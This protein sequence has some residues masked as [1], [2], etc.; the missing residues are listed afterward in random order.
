MHRISSPA[1]AKLDMA[2]Q[3]NAPQRATLHF[4]PTPG[5]LNFTGLSLGRATRSDSH[6]FPVICT[7]EW[8][9]AAWKVVLTCKMNYFQ[10][11]KIHKKIPLACQ[12]ELLHSVPS[13]EST[14]AFR[15]LGLHG[16]MTDSC[17]LSH[18]LLAATP[19]RRMMVPFII[20]ELLIASKYFRVQ[21]V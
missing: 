5:S 12:A 8:K 21:S 11:S 7:R 14:L 16:L 15:T 10:R 19:G 17:L 18:F 20:S 6:S 4:G 9:Q 1:P 3:F 13:A 2:P